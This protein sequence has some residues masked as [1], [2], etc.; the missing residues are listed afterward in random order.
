[1]KKPGYLELGRRTVFGR[2]AK[3][4]VGPVAPPPDPKEY[5]DFDLGT[6]R[7]RPS[8][9][10][11]TRADRIVALDGTTLVTLLCLV[12]AGARGVNRDELLLRV[13]G[14]GEHEAK[15]KR[16]L[17]HLRR[18]FSEDG[19]VR[20]ENAPGDAYVLVVGDAVPGR[21]LRESDGSTLSGMAGAESRW[22]GSKRRRYTAA[23]GAIA[24]VTAIGVSLLL[25]I[26]R[27]NSVTLGSVS[28]TVALATEPGPQ[29]TPSFAP[30]GRQ[31]VYS[32][33]PE[34]E[35][36]AKL[37]VRSTGGV[38]PRPLTKGIRDDVFP[39]WSP[40]GNLV[41][42][43]RL[44]GP[45]C[46]LW[47]IRPD[48]SDETKLAD[49]AVDSAGP[50]EWTNDGNAIVFA[51]RTAP[52]LPTQLVSVT[53]AD[54]KMAGV[55]NP[56]I[57]QPGD[58]LP[59]IASTGRRMVFQRSRSVGVADLQL[60]ETSTGQPERLTKD[61]VETYGAAWEPGNR[62]VI[63]A[64]PR[65]GRSALWRTTIDGRAPRLLLAAAGVD[66]R[67]PVVSND[68]RQLAYERWR[69]QSRL[70]AVPLDSDLERAPTPWLPERGALDRE[71]QLSPDRSR[72]VFVSDR[73]GSDQLWLVDG[74]GA[75]PRQ[76][77]KLELDY[78]QSPRWSPD[79]R[80]IVLAGSRRGEY[81]LWTVDVATG[82]AKKLGGDGPAQAPSF[83][84]D[85]Q[86]LYF[87]SNRT[88]RWEI[89][90]RAWP[91][92]EP[93]QLTTEGGFAALESRD[94]DS[95][96]FVRPDRNGLWKRSR[97]PG[98]DDVLVTPDLFAGD[99]NQFFATEDAIYFV[100]R[101][102][103]E[104]A[105][106]AKYSLTDEAVVRIR[107]LP[108]LLPRSGLTL[109]ADGRSVVVAQLAKTEVHLEMATLE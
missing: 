34:G 81:A 18:I 23:L 20:L 37:Y 78:V 51:Y 98:G 40:S 83:S 6:W 99:W 90:R 65:A 96:Y 44:D 33:K 27:G 73:G 16:V 24:V 101:P 106:L 74:E 25:L 3:K 38:N 53:L 103:K 22:L 109:S 87:T 69:T 95:L 17:S 71:P 5:A 14:R 59:A 55:T 9:G 88:G 79:A 7:V 42:F 43:M 28:G 97:E 77:T 61:G 84:R 67:A 89:W 57:G 76:A 32:W 26:D 13:Y 21:G 36:F 85:G 100:A 62:S 102:D 80:T 64:S 48:G 63:F 54:Q 46:E 2:P 35:K 68:G 29:R 91:E 49:C 66:L 11:M 72:T 70:L 8:L 75:A 50:L 56:V 94:G 93:Q 4:P 107:P 30:D 39:A 12:E 19:S 41:A 15:F 10:R 92:G 31:F 104:N 58:S 45:E 47:A 105:Q 86:W 82:A 52:V 1:M 60:I 108:G